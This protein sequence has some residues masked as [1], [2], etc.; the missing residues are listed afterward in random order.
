MML[1]YLLMA[2]GWIAFFPAV[3]R[4]QHSPDGEV[5]T[6]P[7][8]PIEIQVGK[9]TYHGDSIAHII[10]PT[11]QKYPPLDFKS[12]KERKR[13][14]RLVVNVKK[15]LPLAKL[16]R[17][18][19]I[20]TYEYLNTLPTQKARD[21]HMKQVEKSLQKEFTPVLKKLTRSQGKLLVKLIDRECGQSGYHIAQAFIGSF[22]ANAYQTLAFCFGQSLTKRYDPEGDDRYTERVVLMVES[23]QL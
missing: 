19:V 16:A 5:E 23:G 8:L 4:A 21:A 13:F 15:T 9:T 12:E 7:V 17:M 20:E 6:A 1:K 14:N 3:M 10:F 11:L 22:K 2:F 18:L